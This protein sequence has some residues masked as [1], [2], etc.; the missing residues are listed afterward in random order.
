MTRRVLAI[1]YQFPPDRSVG[2]QSCAQICRYL[3]AHG[4]DVSVL[5]VR[6]SE[7]GPLTADSFATTI[8]RTGVIPHPLAFYRWLKSLKRAPTSEA[9]DRIIMGDSPE[10]RG[11]LRRWLVALLQLPDPYTGWILPGVLSGL[12]AIRRDKVDCLF[13]SGPWWTNHL[14]ALMLARITGLPWIAHFRDS[15]AQ[16]HWVKPVT[17]LSIRIEKAMERLVVRKARAVVCVTDMQ[18]AMLRSANPD[19]PASKFITVPNGYDEA[20]WV[21]PIEAVPDNEKF[22]I[23]YAGNLYHGRSPYPLF[24]AVQSL[25]EEQQIAREKISI[26]LLGVCDVAEGSRVMVVARMHGLADCVS[27]PGVLNKNDTI[28]HMKN[29][30]LLLLLV[31]EQNYSIP[32]KTYEYLRAGRPILALTQGGS[33]VDLLRQSGGAWIVDPTDTV[34]IK[35]AVM[36]AYSAWQRGADARL[37]NNDVVRTYDRRLLTGHLAEV[38]DATTLDQIRASTAATMRSAVWPSHRSGTR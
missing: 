36:E 11:A 16:G 24:R 23:T 18:I 38:F 4:W 27:T 14:V 26:E 21:S 35:T 10:T 34:G 30:S 20:E 32:A 12:A 25:I 8:I 7:A 37:P 3:P 15:W 19:V 22:V 5:T 1:L 31:D 33:V 28:R 9:G 2:A 13:S 29:A 6:R 17:P